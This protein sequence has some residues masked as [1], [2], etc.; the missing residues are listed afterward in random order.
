MKGICFKEHLFNQ[1]IRDYKTQTRRV[2]HSQPE[3]N[4]Y[5]GIQKF[6]EN[7]GCFVFL[8][9][10]DEDE[11]IRP[12]YEVG[13]KVYLK[14]PYFQ[15]SIMLPKQISTY[16]YRYDRDFNTPFVELATG[17]ERWKNKL[18]MPERAAR[19][20]IEITNKKPER[21]QDISDT[22]CMLEGITHLK[23]AV[24]P[25]STLQWC[26][27]MDGMKY[28]SPQEAYHALIDLIDGKGT[29]ESNPW[30]SVYDFKLTTKP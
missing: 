3:S 23:F 14:E 27:G 15:Q 1:V 7:K 24:D 25:G 18:F 13:D 17:K 10:R 2:L 12:R 22:D 20:W 30:V 4:L 29:W 26:N 9:G 28:E 8:K 16:I 11:Y 6:G 5:W 21:L 19:Y